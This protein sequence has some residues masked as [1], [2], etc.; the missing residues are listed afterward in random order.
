MHKTSKNKTSFAPPEE[1]LWII[2]LR[3]VPL[4]NLAL[5]R[6]DL[7]LQ[8]LHLHSQNVQHRSNLL[9]SHVVLHV[10]HQQVVHFQSLGLLQGIVP[11]HVYNLKHHQERPHDNDHIRKI[12]VQHRKKLVQLRNT[13]LGKELQ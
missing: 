13:P 4:H 12:R 11:H 2:N 10:L 8:G 3:G 5:H 9:L 1:E 7:R 6:L